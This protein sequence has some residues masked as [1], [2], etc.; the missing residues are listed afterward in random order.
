MASCTD[1]NVLDL[2]IPEPGAFYVMDRA[3]LD[4]ERLNALHQAAS[5]FVTRAKSNFKCQSILSRPVDR[6]TSLICDQIVEFI[7]FYSEACLGV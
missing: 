7:V 5:C 2:L 3:Y 1:V 4:F 6:S